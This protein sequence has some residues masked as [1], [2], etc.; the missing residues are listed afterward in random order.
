[1]LWKEGDIMT[2]VKL[3]WEENPEDLTKGIG[4]ADDG[5]E[6]PPLLLAGFIGRRRSNGR[7][8]NGE[9]IT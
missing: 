6:G 9:T 2:G 3:P 4:S 8:S 1:M 7:R 5:K